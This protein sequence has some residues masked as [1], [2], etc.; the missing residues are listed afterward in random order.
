MSVDSA[1]QRHSDR[2]PGF[3]HIDANYIFCPNQ[4]FDVCLPNYSRATIRLVAYIIR[5]TLG[6]LDHDGNP[7]AE[8][9]AV[10]YRELSSHAG[11]STRAIPEAI[12]HAEAG[13]LIQCSREGTRATRGE[14]GN[15]AQYSLRWADDDVPY[16]IDHN[17]FSGFFSGEGN[18]SPIPNGFFDHVVPHETLG[19]IK[20][21]GTVLRHTV[22][23]RAK[24]GGGRRIS[25]PLSYDYIQQATNLK[26]RPT[27]SESLRTAG[28]RG[29]IR[30]AEFG[31]FDPDA[32]RTS[33][34]VRYA[35]NWLENAN[36]TA[37]TAKT[38]PVT[39]KHGKNRTGITAENEPEKHGKNRTDRKTERKT[40]YKQQ[41]VVDGLSDSI[42]ALTQEGIT[43][44]TARTLAELRSLDVIRQQ[45]AWLDFRSPENR[46][47][48]LV[49]A[50]EEHWAEPDEVRS[51]NNAQIAKELEA[52]DAAER[53]AHETAIAEQKRRRQQRRRE[54]VVHWKK[55]SPAE[56]RHCR[57][58]TS[59]QASSSVQ[60]QQLIA[61]S[62]DE[63]PMAVLEVMAT[64]I[65]QQSVVIAA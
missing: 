52:Q 30:C 47:A 51:V 34:P 56:K 63:P 24:F 43:E 1:S 19:V 9:I 54:L 49:R 3:D 18:R 37:G 32:G 61:A 8:D 27:L 58:R 39:R 50:I 33:R 22:G 59:E 25:A 4:F 11:I 36:K 55:L 65:A 57:Q 21:V 10:P 16:T 15:A 42:D 7:I 40:S 2:F 13:G 6:H 5:K 48:M 38:E 12:R 31:C 44:S 64:E 20:V 29:Y 46:P 45:I 28:K 62:L 14:R 26:H 53:L 60:R 17:K 23:Y 41:D 35:V